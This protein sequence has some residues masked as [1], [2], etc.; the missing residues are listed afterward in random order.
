MNEYDEI[1]HMNHQL[2]IMKKNNKLLLSQWKKARDIIDTALKT[3]PQQEANLKN[4][5]I[6]S[7]KALLK[8]QV[9]EENSPLKKIHLD[10]M[11]GEAVWV[12]SIEHD[13]RWGI[14][15]TNHETVLFLTKDGIEEEPWFYDKYIFRYKKEI[16]DYSHIL[17][18]YGL[19]DE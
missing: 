2:Y 8:M 6:L 17:E 18:K 9:Q 15:N 4:A 11:N 12:V 5:L 7:T 3:L 14:V 16:K 19:Q 13:G 1:Q 10:N